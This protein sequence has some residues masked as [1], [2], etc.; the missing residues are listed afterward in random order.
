MITLGGRITRQTSRGE[1]HRNESRCECYLLI[2]IKIAI[3]KNDV[4]DLS[5]SLFILSHIASAESRMFLY[6]KN[7]CSFLINVCRAHS[8]HAPLIAQCEQISFS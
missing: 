7:K 4:A 2:A 8:T 5:R 6:F 3:R 1:Y